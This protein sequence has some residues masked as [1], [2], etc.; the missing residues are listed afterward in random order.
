M[1]LA[2]G[3]R[4]FCLTLHL[5]PD[6]DAVIKFTNNLPGYLSTLIVTYRAQYECYTKNTDI[7]SDMTVCKFPGR[8]VHSARSI[9]LRSIPGDT[10]T[11]VN[12]PSDIK[13]QLSQALGKRDEGRLQVCTMQILYVGMAWRGCIVYALLRAK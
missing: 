6:Q 7:S 9:P 11:Q 12:E 1:C 4:L 2:T 10:N 3:A 8:F 5:T 13:T